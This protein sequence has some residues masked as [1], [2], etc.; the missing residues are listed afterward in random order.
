MDIDVAPPQ[1]TLYNTMKSYSIFYG[2]V[3]LGRHMCGSITSAQVME[4]K[5]DIEAIVLY[6]KNGSTPY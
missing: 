5:T 2:N 3:E 1:L 4:I 6:S